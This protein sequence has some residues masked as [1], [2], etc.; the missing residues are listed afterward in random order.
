MLLGGASNEKE[1]SLESGR[2]ICYK[3]SPQK[4]DVT[5][6]FVSSRLELYPL[7][8]SELVRNSTHEIEE[9]LVPENKVAWNDLPSLFDFV[10]IGLHGGHGE[11]GQYKHPGNGACHTNGSSVL[12][13][14][15]CM[16]N[17]NQPRNLRSKGFDVSSIHLISKNRLAN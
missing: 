13:S 9:L 10:F 4:Y 1:I 8:Q 2:K 15:L 16:I 3:L 6:L 7:S 17:L 5:P 14:A 12:A 11:T